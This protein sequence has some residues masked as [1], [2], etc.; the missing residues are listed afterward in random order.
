MTEAAEPES[1]AKLAGSRDLGLGATGHSASCALGASSCS[2]CIAQLSTPQD[3]I[4]AMRKAI[5]E[6]QEPLVTL[7]H[8]LLLCRDE[9]RA[10]W[11]SA[12][13]PRDARR[14][15]SIHQALAEVLPRPV[16][17]RDAR[18]GVRSALVKA[19][20]DLDV[21][22][23]VAARRLAELID[24]RYWHTL[25]GSFSVRSPDQPGVGAPVPL[26]SPDLRNVLAMP[27]STSP[28]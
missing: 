23:V 3:R 21:P 26:D 5:A 1:P 11:E 6:E 27:P 19:F 16:G 15:A 10:L 28:P 14:L 24:K 12:N 9:H 2:V 7:T 8:L 22:P 17:R 13:D 4:D 25:A 20:D 18:P